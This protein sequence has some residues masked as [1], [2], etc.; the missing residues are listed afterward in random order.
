VLGKPG[1]LP[2]HC[3]PG[4]IERAHGCREPRLHAICRNCSAPGPAEPL[5]RLWSDEHDGGVPL[6][7][8]R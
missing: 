6:R 2:A 3:P 5:V 4:G 1:S 7:P 8:G